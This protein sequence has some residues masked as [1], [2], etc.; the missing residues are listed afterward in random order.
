MLV[1]KQGKSRKA[2]EMRADGIR[3]TYGKAIKRKKVIKKR[4]KRVKG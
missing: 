2:K 3:N 4:S 1:F